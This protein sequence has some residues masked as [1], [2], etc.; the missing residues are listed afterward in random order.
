MF[1]FLNT[2]PGERTGVRPLLDRLYQCRKV[3]RSVFFYWVAGVYI[4]AVR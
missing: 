3:Q 2:L 1:F 4:T